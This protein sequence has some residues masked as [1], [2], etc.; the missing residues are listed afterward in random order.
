MKTGKVWLVGAGPGSISLLTIKAAEVLQKADVI[1]YDSLIGTEILS[2]LPKTADYIYVGKRSGQHT[3]P[4]EEINLLLLKEAQKGRFVVRL[5]GGD[6]FL[7][8][9]GGEELELLKEHQIPFE[10]V[11][12]ITS[13][14]AVPEYNGIPVTHRDF[15]SSVHIITGHKKAGSEY[16]ID[17][18]A[19]V[20]TKG[21]LVFLMGISSLP[22]IADSLISAGMD[23][24][25]PAAVLSRGTTA[26]QK[27]VA[28]PLRELPEAVCKIR[29]KTPAVIVVGQV[30]RFSKDFAWY[31]DLPLAGCRILLTRPKELIKKTAAMFRDQGAEVLEMPSISIEPVRDQRKLSMALE[32]INSYDWIVFTSVNGVRIFF[33]EMKHQKKDIRSLGSCRIAS[34]GAGTKNALEERG[35][36][37]DLVPEHYDGV[38]LAGTLADRLTGTEHILIPRAASGNQE[39]IRILHKKPGIQTDD[40]GIY[41]TQY[42]NWQLVPVKEMIESGEIDWTVFTSASTVR[43]FAAA[44]AD[45]C[46]KGMKAA[47]IGEQTA[48][49]AEEVG[50]KVYIAEQASAESLV[51]LVSEHQTGSKL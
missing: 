49:A 12:G 33:E 50:M 44:V 51:R 43:G 36:F 47:C 26:G 42:E 30:C 48:R 9:R 35:L 21:T 3:M 46:I 34:I 29:I 23:P 32:K 18:E 20:R 10:I 38:S 22:D 25:M 4:Q 6:P 28:A 16:D 40:I 41:D 37:C 39:M 17:F 8:G 15:S 11:P 5:K 13:P 2:A 27:R 31:E 1:I 7:F 24:Q 19:L 45:T 14:I